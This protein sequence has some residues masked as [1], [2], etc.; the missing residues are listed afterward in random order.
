MTS[1]LESVILRRISSE[2]NYTVAEAIGKSESTVSRI[3]SGELGVRIG[4]LEAFLT[5]L[6]LKVVGI[7][8]QT[9]AA[10][11]LEALRYLASKGLGCHVD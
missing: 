5:C 6:G 10:K 2:K 11:E 4:E 3:T 7:D 8:E 9:I 1:K